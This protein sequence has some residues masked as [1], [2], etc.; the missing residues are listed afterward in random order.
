MKTYR[1]A[2][3]EKYNSTWCCLA[4]MGS[5]AI[6]GNPVLGADRE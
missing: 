1:L 6:V 3:M 2:T 4:Y 5:G